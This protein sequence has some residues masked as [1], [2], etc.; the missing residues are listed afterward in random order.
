MYI[1]LATGHHINKS[2]ERGRGRAGID[3]WIERIERGT[4][5]GIEGGMGRES[6]G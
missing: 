5:G 3:H 1:L 6:T 4:E 2:L